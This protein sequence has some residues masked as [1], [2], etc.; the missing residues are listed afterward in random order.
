M[1]ISKIQEG[2]LAVTV[3][4]F[5]KDLSS[6]EVKAEKEFKVRVED[7]GE[8]F[9]DDTLYPRTAHDLRRFY[10][11]VALAL[12]DEEIPPMPQNWAAMY[13]SPCKFCPLKEACINYETKGLDKKTFLNDSRDTLRISR[14]NAEVREPSI[15]IP[16]R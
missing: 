4:Q 14:E 9:V 3:Y 10:S 8:I 5:S 12:K 6:L 2:F 7:S 1:L 15:F 16:K 13:G 11:T